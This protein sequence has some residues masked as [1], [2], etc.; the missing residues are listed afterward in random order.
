MFASVLRK[1]GLSCASAILTIS[2]IYD[3]SF[4][5]RLGPWHFSSQ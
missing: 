1:R 2:D 5:S 3:A 4:P